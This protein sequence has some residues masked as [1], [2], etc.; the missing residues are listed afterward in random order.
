MRYLALAE[1]LALHALVIRQSGGA[2]GLR[3]LGG[4]ESA[5][6]Q[7]LVTFGGRELHQGVAEKAAALA[8]SLIRNHPF[9]DGNKRVSHAAMEVF[10][11]LNGRELE[12]DVDE[13][14]KFWLGLAAGDR[15]RSDLAAWISNHLR[16]RQSEEE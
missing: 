16:Q 11:I 8:Y 1:V 12:C 13:Q 9:V 4:L 3:D 15:S 14:E 5:V 10:L 7:P 6:A 2:S